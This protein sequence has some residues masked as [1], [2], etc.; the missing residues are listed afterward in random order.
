MSPQ[1]R[2][3][4]RFLLEHPFCCFCG[5]TRPATTIDHVPPKVCFPVGLCPEGFEFP[6]C[7]QC[8]NG[9]SKFDTIFGFYSLLQDFSELNRTLED[10]KRREKLRNEITRRYPDALPD[11]ATVE[12][13]HRVGRLYAPKPVAFSIKPPPVVNEA[14]D[15]IADKLTHALYYREMK[16]IV[17]TKHR[18]FVARVQIQQEGADKLT[19][20]L[21]NF[22][23]DLEVGARSNLCVC[24]SVWLRVDVLGYG[25]RTG[26]KAR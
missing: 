2:R 18:F 19:A 21:K 9:T 8:N 7:K 16:A 13:V 1:T 6:A 12:P 14:M 24:C 3:K 22:L 20:F 5:G 10:H 26:S 11:P 15:V 23:P 17:T 4:R 25:P